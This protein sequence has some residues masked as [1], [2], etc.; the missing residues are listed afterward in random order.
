VPFAIVVLVQVVALLSCI[1]GIVALARGRGAPTTIAFAVM[2]TLA[3]TAAL[4]WL[5][6]SVLASA[7]I[8][9]SPEL[10]LRIALAD[11]AYVALPITGATIAALHLTRRQSRPSTLAHWASSLGGGLVGWSIAIVLS[12][13]IGPDMVSAVQ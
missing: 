11:L 12:Q 13:W 4:A 9:L 1:S 6:R 10:I 8:E 2:V 3:L 7:A 5:A